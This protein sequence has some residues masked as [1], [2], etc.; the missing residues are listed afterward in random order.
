MYLLVCVYADLGLRCP[1]KADFISLKDVP[2]VM[3]WHLQAWN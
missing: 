2:N 1:H 3:I